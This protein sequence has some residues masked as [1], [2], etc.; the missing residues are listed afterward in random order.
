MS[1]VC[2]MFLS[3]I[4]KTG[5]YA[6]NEVSYYEKRKHNVVVKA[7]EWFPRD[8]IG[9]SATEFLCKLGEVIKATVEAVLK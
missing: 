4:T 7:A 5:Q 1:P 9:S 2:R 6:A 8:R 3:H